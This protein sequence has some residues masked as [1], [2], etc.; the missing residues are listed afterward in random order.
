MSQ[1]NPNS[2]FNWQGKPSIFVKSQDHNGVN[3]ER[4]RRQSKI[5]KQP[6]YLAGSNIYLSIPEKQ[7][8]T[9]TRARS[10]K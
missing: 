8:T 6:V 9:Y 5:E 10:K 3:H 2:P 1:T 7:F 4:S